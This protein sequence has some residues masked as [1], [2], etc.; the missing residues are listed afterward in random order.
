VQSLSEIIKIAAEQ[1]VSLPILQDLELMGYTDIKFEVS[2]ESCP[3]CQSLN[4][5]TWTL[6]EFISGLNHNAPIF[7]HSHIGCKDYIV[8]SGEGK[9]EIKINYKGVV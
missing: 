1:D 9:E 5:R 2:S 7:E 6:K 3:I 8:V 4:G